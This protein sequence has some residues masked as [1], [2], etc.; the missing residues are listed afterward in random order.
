MSTVL[1]VDFAD[2]PARLLQVADM[3]G[4]FATRAT[5]VAEGEPATPAMLEVSPAPLPATPA[6]LDIPAPPLLGY[7]VLPPVPTLPPAS[8]SPEHDAQG[9][10]W[11]GR[12]HSESRALTQD[13]RWRRRRGVD[14]AIVAAVEA[15]LRGVTAAPVA[16]APPPPPPAVAPPPPPPAPVAAAPAPTVTENALKYT[17]ALVDVS[18]ALANQ[19]L[20]LARVTDACTALGITSGIPGL[21]ARPDLIP[22]FRAMLGLG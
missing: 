16:V 7:P 13:G 20:T 8:E 18:T 9:L 22:A 15:E 19:A 14:D 3:I 10:P 11:D 12:I 6:M 5:A 17:Q 2:P 21:E 1:T 4:F